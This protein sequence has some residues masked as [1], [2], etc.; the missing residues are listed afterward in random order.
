MSPRSVGSR[1][2]REMGRRGGG[3]IS[4]DGKSMSGSSNYHHE[5]NYQSNHRSNSCIHR[6]SQSS[7]QSIK[8]STRH[9]WIPAVVMRLYGANI[10]SHVVGG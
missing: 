4:A 1:G 5:K 8:I 6:Y 10:T 7:Y 3:G 2:R 9:Y